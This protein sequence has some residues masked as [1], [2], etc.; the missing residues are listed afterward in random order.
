MCTCASCSYT[1]GFKDKGFAAWP[2]GEPAGPRRS[3]ADY[4]AHVH[5]GKQWGRGYSGVMHEPK[6]CT[7]STAGTRAAPERLVIPKARWEQVGYHRSQRKWIEAPETMPERT[8][9]SSRS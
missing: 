5:Y 6:E 1:D 9:S 8:S 2:R 3:A 7:V 4:A